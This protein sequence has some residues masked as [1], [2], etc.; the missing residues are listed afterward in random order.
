MKI[1]TLVFFFMSSFSLFSS[2]REKNHHIS[3]SFKASNSSENPFLEEQEETS[4]VK[5][6]EIDD[7]KDLFI[8]IENNTKALQNSMRIIENQ[9][10]FVDEILRSME[11]DRAKN[12][13]EDN[14]EGEPSNPFE[15]SHL[16]EIVKGSSSEDLEY[17]LV[18]CLI[19]GSVFKKRGRLPGF[20]KRYLILKKNSL[21]FYMSKKNGKHQ[22][23]IPTRRTSIRPWGAKKIKGK[24]LFCLTRDDLGKA[25]IFSVFD[26][27]LSV[28]EDAFKDH[29]T[30][31]YDNRL[32]QNEETF[33]EIK[34]EEEEQKKS[35][36][37]NILD[38][39][40]SKIE[41]QISFIEEQRNLLIQQKCQAVLV[42]QSYKEHTEEE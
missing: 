28:W 22:T 11:L 23:I 39:L 25:I 37:L 1:F 17:D 2:T 26:D 8:G 24:S 30:L 42:Y 18:N 6:D 31:I 7:S 36:N 14:N 12:E 15:N 27:D 16:D 13:A 40:V 21:V 33:E 5:N 34:L 3:A 20:S 10:S 29:K 35:G 32:F 9:G 19:H 38:S 41:D 4:T